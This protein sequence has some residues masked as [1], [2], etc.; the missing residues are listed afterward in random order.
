MKLSKYPY[1]VQKEILDDMKNADL[2]WLSFVSKNMKTLI[3]SS[4]VKRF[5]S[6]SR[7]MYHSSF[8]DKR[9]VSI[10][11]KTKNRKGTE[12][13]LELEGIMGIFGDCKASEDDCFQLNVS[14]KIIDFRLSNQYTFP[15]ACFHP[16]DKESAIESIHNYFL[17]FFGNTMEYIWRA[18]HPEDII[19][20]LSNLSLWISIWP[21]LSQVIDLKNLEKFFA[22]T[23]VLKNIT[24]KLDKSEPFSPE[25]KFYQAETISIFHQRSKS[26]H[27]L[28]RHFQGRQ[29][30][31]FYCEVDM[32]ELIEFLNR[33]RS[34]EALQKLE[35]LKI[36]LRRD[37]PWHWQPH[38]I[39]NANW[40]KHIEST[41][42]PPIHSVA[43]LYTPG[44]DYKPNTNPITSHT[45]VVRKTDNR[46]ASISVQEGDFVFGVWKETE[47][48][49]LRMVE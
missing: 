10:P 35:Y 30:T 27:A 16:N 33:W 44:P 4:Q 22:S 13:I 18:K 45:Y 42:K 48:E 11:F 17:N 2:F 38:E 9:I 28:L 41:K 20:H 7:I 1:L 39:L 19:P 12:D 8:G 29:A 40:V 23:P 24:M 21:N 47:K 49:F 37:G 36:I 15:E 32:L 14:G 25:S 26:V 5:Q 43:N 34:G 3:K 46:V 6:I 31:L